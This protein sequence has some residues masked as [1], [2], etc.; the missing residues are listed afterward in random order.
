MVRRDLEADGGFAEFFHRPGEGL[1]VESGAAAEAE[2]RGLVDGMGRLN[3]RVPLFG[4]VPPWNQ[5]PK[6]VDPDAPRPF[7]WM[8]EI[9]LGA[10][11]GALADARSPG[12]V[13]NGVG[14]PQAGG[15]HASEAGL[16]R[17]QAR[18]GSP[19]VAS[20]PAKP[21]PISGG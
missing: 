11:A 14:A 6:P 15:S 10:E 8:T 13:Q 1:P 19:G 3:K 12:L 17:G 4:K 7:A 21:K 5:P 18:I 9:P 16:G 2:S 20:E